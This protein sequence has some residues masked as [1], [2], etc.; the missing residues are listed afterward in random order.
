[1]FYPYLVTPF[2]AWFVAG[3]LKFLINSVIARKAATQLIGYGGFPSNHSTIVCSMATLIGLREGLNNPAFGVAVTL[4]F[5]VMLDAASLRR[6]VGK[7]ASTLNQL[8]RNDGHRGL[9]LRERIGHTPVEIIAG[10]VV[11]ALVALV[12]NQYFS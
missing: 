1:M 3:S 10:A 9:Q 12:V 6:H 11:G 5:V 7:H 8:T 2:L 4:A